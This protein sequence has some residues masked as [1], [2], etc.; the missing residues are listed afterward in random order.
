[1]ILIGI[2]IPISVSAANSS[3]AL[4]VSVDYGTEYTFSYNDLEAL[5]ESE[6]SNKYVYSTY[7]TWPTYETEEFYG[8]SV[9]KILAASNID[10][11]SLSDDDVIE[12]TDGEFKAKVTVKDFKE[13]RYYYP[14]GAT[15]N[16]FKGTTS[17]Q[18]EGKSVVPYIISIKD[19]ADNLRNIYG[20]RDPQE[21]QK[22]DYCKYVTDIIIHKNAATDFNGLSPTIANGSYVYEGQKLFFDL[23]K[24]GWK[25]GTG[26][27]AWIYYTVSTDGTIPADPKLSDILF[28]YRQY[29]GWTYWDDPETFNYYKFTDAETTTIK[30]IAYARGY[31]DPI[32]KTL[33]YH[34]AVPMKLTSSLGNHLSPDSNTTLSVANGQAGF[35]YHFVIKNNDTK[36]EWSP[37]EGYQ[38]K[39]SFNW[40]AGPSAAEYGKTVYA[41][42]RDANGHDVIALELPVAVSK[43]PFKVNSISSSK[44]TSLSKNDE[45]TLSAMASGGMA[46]YQYRFRVK[47]NDNG[48]WWTIQDYKANNTCN[49]LAG[50]SAAAKGKTIYVDVKDS[51]GNIASSTLNIEV[52]N[53]N[54]KVASLTSSAGVNVTAPTY[55]TLFAEVQGG[56]S[57]YQFRF[58]VKNNDNGNWYTIQDYKTSDSCNWYCGP[59]GASKGKTVY[60]DVKDAN[61]DV[62][63]K[64]LDFAVSGSNLEV[65]SIS[66]STG[67]KLSPS[68]TTS[69]TAR[70]KGGKSPY[71]YR[72]RV[73]NNDTGNWWTIQ[74]YS[75]SNTCKWYAGPSG[76]TKGKTIYVDVKDA[77]GNITSKMLDMTVK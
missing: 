53:T 22:S 47:N 11:N 40:G 42:V 69:L 51:A 34:A 63:S 44:G 18:Y 25:G 8:P 1:M 62:V 12:F 21:E 58:R 75:T 26:R 55:T 71:Q 74:E 6:G 14:K 77:S 57:P 52:G 4:T 48:N 33:T 56:K 49:W 72:F 66:S 13:T 23:N 24:T 36:K 41:Y 28:N 7:N 17:S 10:I 68:T 45:T 64:T 5:W 3:P 27:Y 76:A 73:R 37:W 39:S 35:T 59:S 60:V 38:A 70:V 20:Q 16:K 15:T 50:P 46:P 9:N 31:K 19:G 2:S 61:G 67:T 54:L 29:G 30:A 32:V 43:T 65:M